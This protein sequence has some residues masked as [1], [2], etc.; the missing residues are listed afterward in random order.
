MCGIAA[1]VDPAAGASLNDLVAM[2]DAVHHRGPDSEGYAIVSAEDIALF[3]GPTTPSFAQAG[4]LPFA[5]TRT[6]AGAAATGWAALSQRRLSILDLSVAGHQ[7]MCDASR[8]RW[9]VFNGE[10]YNFVELRRE[11]EHLGHRFV[12]HSDT[13]VVLA[14]YVEWGARCLERFVGMFALVIVDADAHRVLIARDRFGI[15]PLYYWRTPTGALAFASEIK[16]FTVLPG[17]APAMNGPRV[18][19]FLNLGVHDHTDETMF[20]EVAQLRGGE[21]IDAALAELA[22]QVPVRSWWDLTPEPFSGTFDEAAEEFRTRFNDAVRLHLRADV[23]VGSC[24]S[25]GLDSSSIVRTV[26][27]QLIDGGDQFHQLAFSATSDD[28]RLDESRWMRIVGDA[29]PGLQSHTRTPDMAGLVDLLPR[30]TWHMD[31]PFGSTS[32]LAQ[33][34]VFGLAAEHSIK[35]MLDGQ[36]ADEQL[37]G[38]EYYFAWRMQEL[39][40]SGR[41]G[42]LGREAA[43]VRR[44]HGSALRSIA[45]TSAYLSLPRRLGRLGGRLVDAPGQHPDSWLDRTRL[46]VDGYPDALAEH[47]ARTP[48]V[49]GLGRAQL[50]RT[51]LPMLLHYEDRDSMAHS[52]EAR[53]PF[54]DH[55]LVE[56][57]VGLPSEYLISQGMTKRVLR[58]AM[59]GVLPEVVR[60]RVDKIGFATAEE[61]WLRGEPSAVVLDLVRRA[62]DLSGGAVSPGAL[63]RAVGILDG[64]RRFDQ[65]LWRLIS[66]GAWLDRF[67]VKGAGG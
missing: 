42:G 60:Q 19:D 11:L 20:A 31:E 16:A 65:S 62:V 24:L 43:D 1:L 58:A 12:G 13:E 50:L 33:W 66:L 63:R 46:G 36:G 26:N 59:K 56:F 64:S 28:V 40:R 14:S 3:S 57:V 7:P 35:V 4:A 27:Q 15:K 29:T 22:H 61:T 6:V 47:G 51:N 34:T 53:V 18:Y 67:D 9:I 30:L 45:M 38:Y 5:P 48:S 52:I 39:L 8:R 10:V 23:P 44:L 21:C 54:L 17:W 2:T 37:A 55:R 25:G 49:Q 41:L 32:I